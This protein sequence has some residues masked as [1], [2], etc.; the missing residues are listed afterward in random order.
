MQS[1]D[2]VER[3][4]QPRRAVTHYKWDA[5]LNMCVC[6][7]T[8]RPACVAVGPRQMLVLTEIQSCYATYSSR[9]HAVHSVV[10]IEKPWIRTGWK[11]PSRQALLQYLSRVVIHIHISRYVFL[12]VEKTADLPNKNTAQLN[13]LYVW[14]KALPLTSWRW[15]QVVPPKRS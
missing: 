3:R 2:L 12:A 14:R 13:S 6:R 9:N 8:D 5:L 7:E 1:I 15:E 11:W 4:S 10:I